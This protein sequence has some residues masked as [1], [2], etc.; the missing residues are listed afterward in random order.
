MSASELAGMLLDS[1]NNKL[2]K[3]PDDTVILPAHGAGSLCGAH[4]SEEP[5]STIGQEKVSNFYLK[6]AGDRS[7]FIASVISGLGKAPGYFGENARINR[8]GPEIVDWKN[9]FKSRITD[10]TSLSNK[11]L[12]Y[13]ID[14]RDATSYSAA[15]IPNSVNIALRGRFETWTGIIVPW[16]SNLV[17]VGDDKETFEAA[18]RLKRIGYETSFLNFSDY[19][20]AGEKIISS[21]MIKPSELKV[22]MEERK[23]P[24][25][26][27]VRLPKEWTGLRI[28]EVVNI[29]LN[30]LEAIS[31]SRLNKNEE[32]VAVCNSAFRSSLAIGLLERNGF[33]KAMSMEGGADAWV[34]AGYPVIRELEKNNSGV[35]QETYRNFGLPERIS[36]K[37]L[38]QIIKD[39]PGTVEIIDLRPKSQVDAYNPTGARPADIANVLENLTYLA[40]DVP[41][42]IVDRDGTLSMMVAGILSRKTKR[43]IKAV[44]GGVESIWREVEMKFG[45]T[46]INPTSGKSSQPTSSYKENS[47]SPAGSSVPRETAPEAKPKRKSAGC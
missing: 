47:G 37:A 45:D 12:F 39:L 15:H 44:I 30:E 43:N 11:N 7:A 16:G 4:L 2:S 14:T 3:L 46:M 26:V 24:L 20:K 38:L 17:V 28:G 1:W 21:P 36:A 18:S 22:R 32:V 9:P 41:L 8:E 40:G 34:E 19:Q 10:F 13:V 42:V 27:D 6:N 5:S 33:K 31:S 25:I 35:G 29:P 23:A